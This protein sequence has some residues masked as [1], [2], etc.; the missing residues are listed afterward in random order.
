MLGD[1]HVEATVP[2]TD[3]EASREFYQNRLGLRPAGAHVPGV[4]ELYELA[5]GSRLLI[6]VHPTMIAPPHTAAHF[7]VEDVRETVRMLRE[8]GVVFEEYDL[9]KLR[10]VDGVANIRGLDF[11]WFKDPDRN[12][13]GIHN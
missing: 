11:A 12:V 13:L 10:T 1:A 2:V 7:I 6:Y 4:E 9:P 8:R 5:A 3:L